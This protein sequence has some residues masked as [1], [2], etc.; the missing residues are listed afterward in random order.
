MTNYHKLGGLNNG[1]L[2]SHSSVVQKCKIKVLTGLIPSE[3]PEVE[4]VSWF[5]SS[6]WWFSSNLWCSLA[7]IHTTLSL[8]LHLP[9]VLPV[10]MSVGPLFY[11]DMHHS[12]LR[13]H[14]T[15]V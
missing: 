12:G 11:K 14:P 5:S 9:G 3:G 6:F 15:Q 2:S 7:S 8:P 13:G 1:N 4:Y 10:C